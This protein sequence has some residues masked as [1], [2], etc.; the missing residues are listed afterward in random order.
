[1][2]TISQLTNFYYKSLHPT[3]TELEA[4]RLALKKRV[5]IIQAILAIIA[6]AIL[7]FMFKSSVFSIDILAFVGFSYFALAGFT[8]KLLVKDYAKDFKFR[9]ITPLI[10]EIDINLRYT[11]SLHISEMHYT[12]SGIFTSSP[13]RVSGNDFVKGKIDGISIE[14]SDFHAEIEHKDSKGRRSWSTQFQGLFLVSEFPKH[15]KGKTVIL[16]DTAQSI[17][18]D[19]IGSFLQSNNFSRNDLIKMDNPVFEKEFVVYGTNQIEARYI[20]S[21]TLME[22]I[23]DFKRRSNHPIN[24][25]FNGGKIYMAIEYNKDLFE[26]SVFHSLL[27][28]KIAMEYVE[29]LHLAIGIVEELKLNEKLWSKL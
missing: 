1:M 25:S 17:F 26:P 8:Y 18:G 21:H 3:L 13:D 19:F 28:Y 9:V 16:P 15:F 11:P 29:T 24:L 22:K 4:D 6:T 23:L 20:L 27:K 5:I 10:K 2:K 14:F 12:R 7:Y